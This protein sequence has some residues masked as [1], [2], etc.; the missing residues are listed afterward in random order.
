MSKETIQEHVQRR[1]KEN[2]LKPMS[3]QRIDMSKNFSD[4]LEKLLM[5]N[6]KKWLTVNENSAQITMAMVT[7]MIHKALNIMKEGGISEAEVTDM[8]QTTIRLTFSNDLSEI[9]KK[10]KKATKRNRTHR[11]L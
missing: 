2:G 1:F 4:N 6:H 7:S 10:A 8:V 11:G 9:I 5:E 3:Y